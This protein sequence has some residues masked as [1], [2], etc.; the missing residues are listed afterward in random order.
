[1]LKT[2]H[3]HQKFTVIVLVAL[4]GSMIFFGVD[5]GNQQQTY[6]LKINDKEIS[7]GEFSD[8]ARALENQMRQQYGQMYDMLANNPD[9]SINQQAL[10]AIIP[11]TLL[12]EK[13]VND[14]LQVS[15]ETLVKKIMELFPENSYADYLKYTGTSAHSFEEKLRSDLT[16]QQLIDFMNLN[17]QASE[18]EAKLL[19]KKENEKRTVDFLRI[20][21]AE[22]LKIAAEPSSEELQKYYEENLT[23]FE[24]EEQIKYD[25]LSIGENQVKDIIQV[26]QEDIELYYSE[27]ENEF[28][29]P[30]EAKAQHIQLTLPPNA[31]AEKV[32]E[33]KAKAEEVLGKVLAGTK[34]EELVNQYSDDF[35]TKVNGGNL[36]LIKNDNTEDAQAPLRKAIFELTEPGICK[37]VEAKYGYHI[38]KVNELKDGAL[39]KLEE[40]KDQIIAKIKDREAVAYTSVYAGE[41]FEEWQKSKQS[42]TEFAKT[43]NLAVDHTELLTKGNDPVNLNGLTAELIELNSEKQQLI[44]RQETALLVEV[45]DFKARSIPELE[46]VK[47]KVVEKLKAQNTKAKIKEKAAEISEALKNGEKFEVLAEKH[48]LKIETKNDLNLKTGLDASYKNS[49]LSSAIFKTKSLEDTNNQSFTVDNDLLFFK[50]KEIISP[51]AEEFE[52]VKKEYLDRTTKDNQRQLLDALSNYLKSRAEMDV[53][54]DL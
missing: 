50:V 33:I 11:K 38:V 31:P 41:L 34:F 26:S 12:S 5:L 10:D 40:V 45:L 29:N 49:D 27:N 1:M 15:N 52:K 18:V 14:N 35:P 42:L 47:T 3:K 30:R 16:R 46:V 2:I 24:T 9:W 28:T 32:A 36:G 54:I 19:W 43:K 48:G 39:K 37:L 7:Y 4:A 22:Q 20:S 13:A 51:K 17:S 25:Y 21:Y 44:D 23:D 6:A 8:E 53:R